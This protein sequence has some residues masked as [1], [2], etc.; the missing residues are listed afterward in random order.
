MCGGCLQPGLCGP[1]QPVAFTLFEPHHV[2]HTCSHQPC[3]SVFVQSSILHSSYCISLC[4][5][6]W[7]G[8]SFHLSESSFL[9]ICWTKWE[10]VPAGTSVDTRCGEIPTCIHKMNVSL[11]TG[12]D[13]DT[14]RE[15]RLSTT[16][17]R[18][19]VTD[20]CYQGGLW[21]SPVTVA[22]PFL[23]PTVCGP[24]WPAEA[25]QAGRDD[26]CSGQQLLNKMELK[27]STPSSHKQ[28][29]DMIYMLWETEKTMHLAAG[30]L[31][32][33]F[34]WHIWYEKQ[35]SLCFKMKSKK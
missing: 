35:Y 7:P 30:Q 1:L 5:K 8:L 6:H 19:T 15:Q 17:S 9:S 29:Q 21:D 27:N 24:S 25:P 31:S 22:V 3:E 18:S 11:G 2:L 16:F 23:I 34:L 10:H 12:I 20:P 33:L 32:I 26:C 13:T 4:C 14:H 28:H